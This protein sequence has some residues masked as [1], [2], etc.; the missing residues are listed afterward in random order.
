VIS[1]ESQAFVWVWLPEATS[2]IV[3]R[4]EVCD[5]AK[6]TTLQQKQLTGTAVLNPFCFYDEP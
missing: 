2:P 4:P 3:D 6:L 5:H 1:N